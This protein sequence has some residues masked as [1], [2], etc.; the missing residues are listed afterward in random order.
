MNLAI[1]KILHQLIDVASLVERAIGAVGFREGANSSQAAEAGVRESVNRVEEV[2]VIGA[3][4]R[5]H[6][7]RRSVARRDPR[8]YRT[9][10]PNWV[11]NSRISVRRYTNAHPSHRRRLHLSRDLVTTGRR[12]DDRYE[13]VHTQ[14]V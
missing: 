9:R 1:C 10:R 7:A 2:G 4:H 3:R 12:E 13:S 14:R 11:G 8:Y 6:V 5:E